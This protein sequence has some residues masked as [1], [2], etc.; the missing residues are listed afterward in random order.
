MR[1]SLLKADVDLLNGPIFKS[2]VIF[3]IPLL[4]SNVF[5]Q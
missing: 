2:L 3:M 5:Q 1:K 4:I